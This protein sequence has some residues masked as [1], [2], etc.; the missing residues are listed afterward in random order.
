MI[1]S[2]DRQAGLL[3]NNIGLIAPE[4]TTWPWRHPVRPACLASLR[5]P[6]PGGPPSVPSGR[7]GG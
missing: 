4:G 1:A 7:S 5:L 3:A 6:R 2:S